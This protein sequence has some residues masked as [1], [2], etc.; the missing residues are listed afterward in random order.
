MA[1]QNR[2]VF[3]QIN[4]S[5]KQRGLPLITWKEFLSLKNDKWILRERKKIQDFVEPDPP[6]Q[7][8]RPKAVYDNKSVYEKYDI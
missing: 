6:K 5:R 4:E 8:V 2:W 3:D 7:F 1:H